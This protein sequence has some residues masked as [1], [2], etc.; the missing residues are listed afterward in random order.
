MNLPSLG[1]FATSQHIAGDKS[2]P[3][4]KGTRERIRR[5]GA[6]R[7]RRE[8][9]RVNARINARFKRLVFQASRREGKCV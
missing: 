8:T 9:R 2:L 5:C 6:A 1:S 7:L 3:S 4:R